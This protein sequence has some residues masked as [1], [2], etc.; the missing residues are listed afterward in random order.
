MRRFIILRGKPAAESVS[1]TQHSSTHCNIGMAS[2]SK[3]HHDYQAMHSGTAVARA[4]FKDKLHVGESELLSRG[5][6]IG[7]IEDQVHAT[8]AALLVSDHARY[9]IRLQECDEIGL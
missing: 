8:P 6:L 3:S 2:R 9:D 1:C 7:R 4:H 5:A